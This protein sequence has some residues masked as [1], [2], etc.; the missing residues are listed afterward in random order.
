MFQLVLF[1]LVPLVVVTFTAAVMEADGSTVTVEEPF[2]VTELIVMAA[3]MEEE[4][5]R[6]KRNVRTRLKM[7]LGQ[8]LYM[9]VGDLFHCTHPRDLVG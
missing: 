3:W 7:C 5:K 8:D 9:L 4:R 1:Q 6:K 2:K